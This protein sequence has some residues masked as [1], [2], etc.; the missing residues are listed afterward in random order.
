MAGALALAVIGGGAAGASNFGFVG[1]LANI[2]SGANDK[3]A[4]NAAGEVDKSDEQYQE[5]I[6][7]DVNAAAGTYASEMAAQATSELNRG[8]GEV[9]SHYEDL[10]TDLETTVNTSLTNG[11]ALVTTKVNAQVLSSE[12]AIENAAVNAINAQ[13]QRD[14]VT[15][16]VSGGKVVN[17]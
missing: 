16:Y 14:A 8:K 7:N 13:L 5:K 6:V 2:L 15:K 9:K 4:T 3:I 10:K 12:A 11:K 17:R 1:Q